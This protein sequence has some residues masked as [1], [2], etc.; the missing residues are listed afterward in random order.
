L[1]DVDLGILGYRY[2]IHPAAMSIEYA[3]GVELPRG[4]GSM[5]LANATMQQPTDVNADLYASTAVGSASELGPAC[6]YHLHRAAADYGIH[7]LHGLHAPF[8]GGG[9]V[10]ATLTPRETALTPAMRRQLELIRSHVVAGVAQRQVLANDVLSPRERRV[11]ELLAQGLTQK[12]VAYTLVI[13]AP[14]VRVLLHRAA[15]K[16]GVVDRATLLER[17]RRELGR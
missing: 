17:A 2:H 1:F 12:E 14:T 15:R 9:Y 4:L 10:F 11:L 16:L 7:D 3:H 6:L 8:A 13:A 5:D